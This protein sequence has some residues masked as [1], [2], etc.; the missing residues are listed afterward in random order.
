[1]PGR[2]LLRLPGTGTHRGS[3]EKRIERAAGSERGSPWQPGMETS[4]KCVKRGEL[5]KIKMQS[6]V[7]K[8]FSLTLLLLTTFQLH[9]HVTCHMAP[10]LELPGGAGA[11]PPPA[12]AC[13]S[14]SKVAVK[15]LVFQ[16]CHVPAAASGSSPAPRPGCIFRAG[17]WLGMLLPGVPLHGSLCCCHPPGTRP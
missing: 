4:P 5:K 8:H 16:R 2:T 14:L 9:P 11:E 13:P 3:R 6:G 15:S 17:P 12:P 7:N 1:M 10:V